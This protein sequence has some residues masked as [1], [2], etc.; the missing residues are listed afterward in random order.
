M[1]ILTDVANSVDA[2][3]CLPF[4]AKTTDT[5]GV[6]VD[7]RTWDLQ[8]AAV[9]VIGAVTDGTHT[10][11]LQEST[12]GTTWSA[13]TTFTAFTSGAANTN[14]TTVK[15]VLNFKRNYRYVRATMTATTITSGGVY[16]VL[17]LGQ[18]K[19]TGGTVQTN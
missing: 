3:V 5:A 8:H 6:S 19:Q 4:A 15:Q 7:C 10:T 16:G 14:G 11:T 2:K 12:D 17:L 9:L 18:K 1:N 13:V